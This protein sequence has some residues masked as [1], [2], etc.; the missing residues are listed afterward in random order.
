[1]KKL[2]LIL[3]GLYFSVSFSQET[4]LV[5]NKIDQN[6]F[7]LDG[8]VTENEID[9]AKILEIIYEVEPGLNTMPSQE[10]TGYLTYT[11]KFL[12]VGVKAAR[13]KV[14]APLTTRDNSSFWR[15]DFAGLTIDSYGDARNNIIIILFMLYIM[16]NIFLLPIVFI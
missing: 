9:G 13:K 7:N 5:L 12:Y 11:E 10:T 14:I 2:F 16:I 3:F 6:K 8:V 1:M 4:I 15:G